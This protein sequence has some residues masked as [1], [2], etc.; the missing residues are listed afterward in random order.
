MQMLRVV[1]TLALLIGLMV[2]AAAQEALPAPPDTGAIPAVVLEYKVTFA[3]YYYGSPADSA[4]HPLNQLRA[5][6]QRWA[7]AN[8]ATLEVRFPRI[9]SSPASTPDAYTATVELWV[10]ADPTLRAELLEQLRPLA[11]LPQ[12]TM[13]QAGYRWEKAPRVRWPDRLIVV[14]GQALTL[15]ELTDSEY[16]ALEGF[17]DIKPWDPLLHYVAGLELS[18]RLPVAA[19]VSVRFGRGGALVIRDYA[20]ALPTGGME[21]PSYLG[22]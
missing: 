1:L 5:A 16:A 17:L 3:D 20:D 13:S 8:G 9:L 11:G 19:V 6:T 2:L 18:P 4:M 12:R 10:D 7:E 15:A 22:S 21:V 14:N